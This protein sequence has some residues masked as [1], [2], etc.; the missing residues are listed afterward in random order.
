MPST[1]IVGL[2]RVDK[3]IADRHDHGN[4][5]WADVSLYLLGTAT[6]NNGEMCLANRMLKLDSKKK[7]I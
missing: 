7:W 5:N 6:Q 4:G 2:Q 3:K 1:I